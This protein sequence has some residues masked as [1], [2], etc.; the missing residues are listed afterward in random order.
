MPW[1]KEY[2]IQTVCQNN[3]RSGYSLISGIRGFASQQG[4]VFRVRPLELS[5][6]FGLEL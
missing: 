3:Y 5:I 6:L 1:V 4:L 2:V